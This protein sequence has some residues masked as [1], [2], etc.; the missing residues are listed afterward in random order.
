LLL[1]ERV[2]LRFFSAHINDP[3]L[4]VDGDGSGLNFSCTANSSVTIEDILQPVL[5]SVKYGDHGAYLIVGIRPGIIFH[6]F[7][8]M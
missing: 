1:N 6:C 2:D 8:A 5:V 3:L 7:P 4:P